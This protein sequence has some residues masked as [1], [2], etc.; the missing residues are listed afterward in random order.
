MAARVTYRAVANAF[1]PPIAESVVTVVRTS[2]VDGVRR[3]VDEEG[4]PVARSADGPCP[5]LRRLSAFPA[6]SGS[7]NPTSEPHQVRTSPV[8]ALR[9]GGRAVVGGLP[10]RAVDLRDRGL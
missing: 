4:T 9:R 6:R 10:R 8:A 1:P 5:G 2:L 3:A 7:P